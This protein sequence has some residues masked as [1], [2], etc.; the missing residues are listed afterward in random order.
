MS[1]QFAAALAS[2][3]PGDLAERVLATLPEVEGANLG[4][5][6]A[7]EAAAPVLAAL[8]AAVSRARGI[9]S[10]VGG[11][12]LGVVGTLAPD[13]LGAGQG[14]GSAEIMDEPAVAVMIAA[15]PPDGFRVFAT[16]AEPA[17]DLPRRHGGWIAAK[18]PVLALV[19][20]DPRCRS[21]TRATAESAAASGAY[22]VGG[23]VSHRWPS[24]LVAQDG[25][26]GGFG[27]GGI[28][29]VMLASEVALATALTQGC[30]PIGPVHRVD[31][32]RDN[33]VMAID[34]RPALAVFR[35]DVGPALAQDLRR[36]GGLIFAGF[37]VAGSD[38]GDYL[39]RNLMAIDPS[40]GWLVLG[41]EVAPG[42]RIL[43]C[44][45]DP[46]AA[47]RD[48]G[49]MIQQLKGRLGGVP[50]AA[51]YVSCVARGVNLFGEEGVETE[52]IREAFGDI[53]LV[54]FFA[55]GEISRDRLY[56]HTG[57]LTVFV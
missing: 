8:V 37:P 54:G 19:H 57:V 35:D 2:G 6:Y 29:G 10:W 33:V 49:R 7:T 43:F 11:V 22:L 51:L 55:N 5:I 31:E 42:D 4:I 9:G 46:E 27:S 13:L 30:S 21:L 1:R 52:L 28:A 36:V 38:T 32:A 34:G 24:P 44:R 14:P 56:G 16:T 12:G 41:E 18:P 15:L 23:L 47:R 25:G 17:A 3:D 50:K 40:H 39:V 53:P 48:M 20:A 26:A 45:R